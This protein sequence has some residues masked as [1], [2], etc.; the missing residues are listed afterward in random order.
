MAKRTI[1]IGNT[2]DDVK[3]L[4]TALATA[5]L[6]TDKVDG[7]FGPRTARAVLAFQKLRGLVEDGVAGAKTWAALE[8]GVAHPDVK[9]GDALDSPKTVTP[10][11]EDPGPP[12]LFFDLYPYDLDDRRTKQIDDPDF[13]KVFGKPG[14]FGGILKATDGV[15]YGFVDWFVRNFKALKTIAGVSY[16]K[17]WFRGGYHYLQFWAD[18]KAQAD[19][20]C[21]AIE[22]AGGWDDGVIMPIVDVEEG[23][24]RAANRRASDQQV[25]DSASAFAARC[26]ERTGRRCM[27]Y[28]RGS[29]RDRGIFSKMG[30]DVVW[31]PAYTELMVTN[32]LV[33]I[34]GRPGPW[35][36]ED[37]SLWQYGGD[38][39][40]D[41]DVHKLPLEIAGF[42][43]IDMSVHVCGAKAPTIRTL[44]AAII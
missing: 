39:V 7:I 41:A 31:N 25:I 21:N 16:A 42:G 14:I 38:G 4:Q 30:C 13:S 19:F 22:K 33:T 23:N 10:S 3:E 17:T 36:L 32:G 12:Y 40:G 1:R 24:E 35:R 34:G 43:K 5:G 18:G 28:G 20:Y 44:R 11:V 6:Y 15:A 26:K 27:L 8:A 29:M 2:G 9:I 37:I